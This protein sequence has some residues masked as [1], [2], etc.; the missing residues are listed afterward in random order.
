MNRRLWLAALLLPLAAGAECAERNIAIGLVL[1]YRATLPTQIVFL[2][3]DGR[4]IIDERTLVLHIGPGGKQEAVPAP[5]GANPAPREIA[6]VWRYQETAPDEKAS[7]NTDANKVPLREAHA[8][9]PVRSEMTAE[10]LG[11]LEKD[12]EHH[13]LRL[14]LI[15]D[16]DRLGVRWRVER[17]R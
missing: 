16:R 9:V 13:L 1:F 17:R 11:L 2:D 8:T 4:R 14:E 15:F 5:R 7:I 6:A 3:L 12:P 10:A